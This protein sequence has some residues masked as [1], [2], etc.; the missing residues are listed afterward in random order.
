M[1]ISYVTMYGM[2]GKYDYSS[3]GLWLNMATLIY[4]DMH[5]IVKGQGP[6]LHMMV[7][8]V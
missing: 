8:L 7:D 6:I 1:Q 5:Y 4:M 3:A 2:Y